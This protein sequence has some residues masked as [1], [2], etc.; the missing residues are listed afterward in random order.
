MQELAEGKKEAKEKAYQLSN[1]QAEEDAINNIGRL[2]VSQRHHGI[3]SRRP[4][5]RNKTGRQRYGEQNNGHAGK[6]PR[7]R[8][9]QAVELARYQARQ[10]KGCR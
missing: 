1:Q 10:P 7:I 5:R 3:D 2:F 8:C 6:S 4:P 9:A